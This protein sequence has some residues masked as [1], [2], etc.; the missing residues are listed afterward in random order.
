VKEFSQRLFTGIIFVSVIIAGM[1][2][3]QYSYLLVFFSAMVVGMLEFTRLVSTSTVSVQKGL[4]ILLGVFWYIALFFILSGKISQLWI[5]FTVPMIMAVF[6][7][8]LF[9]NK[10]TPVQ[11]IACTLLV[12]FYVAL[13][14]SCIHFIVFATGSY[15][16]EILLGFFLLVWA[17]DTGAYLVGVTMGKHKLFPRISPKKS[18][19][20]AIGGFV[21]TLLVAWALNYACPALSLAHCI[22]IGAIISVMGTFG[23]LVESLLKRSAKIKDSGKILPGHGGIL[24]RFDA[25]LFAAPMVCCYLVVI[26]YIL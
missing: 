21:L 18:W 15:S 23:D 11:N 5:I 9:R 22:A 4:A 24:D 17:N 1:W 13:P 7:I 3:H 26:G 6:I 14:F 10:E 16:F 19:E 8:E 20:G 2:W 25:V 12:P